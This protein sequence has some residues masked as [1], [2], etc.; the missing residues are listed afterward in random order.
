MLSLH[1]SYFLGHIIEIYYA[2]EYGSDGEFLYLESSI[3]MA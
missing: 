2:L 1:Q 3:I